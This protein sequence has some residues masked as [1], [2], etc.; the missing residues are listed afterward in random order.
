MDGFYRR[1]NCARFVLLLLYGA[2]RKGIG[3]KKEAFRLLVVLNFWVNPADRKWSWVLCGLLLLWPW[4]ITIKYNANLNFYPVPIFLIRSISYKYRRVNVF[5]RWVKPRYAI[6]ALYQHPTNR[7]T[8]KRSPR[9]SFLISYFLWLRNSVSN[10]F[11]W[12]YGF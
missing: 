3:I 1:I 11:Y 12:T 2:F 9:A 5:Q 4:V 7:R 8:Q 6:I 10:E